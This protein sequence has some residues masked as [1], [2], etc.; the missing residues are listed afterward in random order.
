M[1]FG[2]ARWRPERRWRMPTGQRTAGSRAGTIGTS[3]GGGIRWR[4]SSFRSSSCGR[5]VAT[6]GGDSR[7]TS[8]R[9]RWPTWISRCQTP[10]RRRSRRWSGCATTATGPGGGAREGAEGLPFAFAEY[11][12]TYFD[13]GGH[14][15]DPDGVLPLGDLIQGMYSSV[16][17]FSE[18]GDG[19]VVQTPIYPPFLDTIAHHRAPA[20]SRTAWSTTGRSYAVDVDGLREGDRQG[21]PA[22]D[23]PQSAQPDWPGVHPRRAS[24][25]GRSRRRARPDRR[26]G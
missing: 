3:L 23:G 26:L 18:P 4:R 13:W 8:C 1:P 15:V 19:I 25:D 17:A 14:T 9:P 12:S 20:W 24:G 6:S 7:Q 21:H 10:F 22:A 11:A 5:G 2:P 16:Y